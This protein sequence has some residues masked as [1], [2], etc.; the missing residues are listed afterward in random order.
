MLLT[1]Y[2]LKLNLSFLKPKVY[3]SFDSFLYHPD[4]TYPTV[5]FQN[6]AHSHF[7]NFQ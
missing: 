3:G 6:C 5:K 7:H 1:Q 4:I 2:N